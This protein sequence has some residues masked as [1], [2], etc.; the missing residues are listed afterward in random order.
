MCRGVALDIRPGHRP[1]AHRVDPVDDRRHI[2][3]GV[4]I[5][6]VVPPH[7]VCRAGADVVA[8][9]AGCRA[10]R[11][12]RL[13][14]HH[15]V[16]LAGG[17]PPVEPLEDVLQ[18]Q[19][20]VVEARLTTRGAIVGRRVMRPCRIRIVVGNGLGVLCQASTVDDR[21]SNSR[22]L[23]GADAPRNSSC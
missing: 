15:I 21:L 1:I 19:H 23:G 8:I 22:D 12:V 17:M 5:D 10:G 4:G 18:V 13:L 9:I 14:H 16:P 2:A 20:D 7:C 3:G 11:G 6:L